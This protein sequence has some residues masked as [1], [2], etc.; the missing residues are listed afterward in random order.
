MEIA[1]IIGFLGIAAYV[2][3]IYNRIIALQQTRKNSFADIDVQMKQRYDLIPNLVETVKKYAQHERD[4]FESVTESR[5]KS[6]Q[7]KTAGEKGGAE[8]GLDKALMNLLAVAE[9]YPDLKADGAFIKFQNEL[10]NLENSIA[11][12]R[13]FYNNSTAELNTATQQFPA[14]FIA[15]AFAIKTE[16]EFFGVAEEQKNAPKIEL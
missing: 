5:S 1:I 8:L 13:R 6:M 10:A 15:K 7:A 11:A 14:N 16:S 2:V 12:A 9:N 3:M 4:V